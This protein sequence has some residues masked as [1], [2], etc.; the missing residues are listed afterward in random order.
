MELRF[1]EEEAALQAKVR[2]MATEKL[3]PIADEIEECDDIKPEMVKIMADE[4]LFRF[5]FPKEYGGL[6]ELSSVKLCIIREE[7][8]RVSL[9][10]DTTFAMSGLG[11]YPI[12][13]YGTE[14]Q[15]RK[16]IPPLAAGEKLGS[17][18]L[19]EPQSALMSPAG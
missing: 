1:N 9:V 7:I 13:A 8:S 15:K 18:G 10:A 3:A 6:G 12:A 16:Y 19:S 14:E 2:K 17:L 11:C 5:L 4:G